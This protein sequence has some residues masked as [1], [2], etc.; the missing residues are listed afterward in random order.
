VVLAIAGVESPAES[1]MLHR[2]L[3]ISMETAFGRE[4]Q[5]FQVAEEDVMNLRRALTLARS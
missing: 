1:P 2:N 3:R 4:Y 5:R